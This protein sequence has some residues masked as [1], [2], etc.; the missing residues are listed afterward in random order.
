MAWPYKAGLLSALPAATVCHI[1][2]NQLQLLG[3]LLG[4]ASG[5]LEVFMQCERGVADENHGEWSINMAN[6]VC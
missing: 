1:P 6:G 5:V 3:S 4:S 2:G